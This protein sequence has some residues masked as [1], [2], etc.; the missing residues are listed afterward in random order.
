MFAS[1][2]LVIN[3][4]ENV[5]FRPPRARFL[6]I[7]SEAKTFT[8]SLATGMRQSHAAAE[9]RQSQLTHSHSQTRARRAADEDAAAVVPASRVRQEGGRPLCKHEACAVRR[10][11]RR[12]G[13]SD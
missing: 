13:L 12:P 1:E 7:T 10:H 2:F 4:T 5:N 8:V 6:G 3:K 11:N 9:E